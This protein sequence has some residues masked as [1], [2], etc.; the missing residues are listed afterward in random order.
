MKYI[1]VVWIQSSF[2]S[3]TLSRVVGFKVLRLTLKKKKKVICDSPFGE[4]LSPFQVL[5]FC[6]RSRRKGTGSKMK[7]TQKGE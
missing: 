6:G 2:S 7:N 1:L 4:V 3:S 5:K